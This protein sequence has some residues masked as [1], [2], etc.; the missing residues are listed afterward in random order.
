VFLQIQEKKRTEE[1]NLAVELR[2]HYDAL[3]KKTEVLAKSKI[4]LETQLKSLL[5]NFLT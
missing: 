2:K 4:D 1:S 5:N 3:K